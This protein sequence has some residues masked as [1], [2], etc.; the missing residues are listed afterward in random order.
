MYGGGGA[1]YVW[2]GGVVV[3]SDTHI[4]IENSIGILS[5]HCLEYTCSQQDVCDSTCCKNWY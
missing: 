2:R 1:I 3:V 4:V 5:G